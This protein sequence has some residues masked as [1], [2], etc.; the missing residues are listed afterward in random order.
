MM[1]M[2]D[3]DLERIQEIKTLSTDFLAEALNWW[4]S[5]ATEKLKRFVIIT[6]YYEFL[7]MQAE[8]V[9]DFLADIVEEGEV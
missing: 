2:S 9:D 3:D 6:C 1:E 5:E 8:G 4:N 7:T